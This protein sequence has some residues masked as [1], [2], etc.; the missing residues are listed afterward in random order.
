MSENAYLHHWTKGRLC[1]WEDVVPV[2]A[3]AWDR[4]VDT[5]DL[6]RQ[7]RVCDCDY[8]VGSEEKPSG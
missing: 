8:S 2:I 4:V 7:H 3:A 6:D 1:A 5:D